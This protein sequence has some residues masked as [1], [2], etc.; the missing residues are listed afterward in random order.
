MKILINTP[1]LNLEGGVA[2][3]YKGLFHHWNEEVSYNIIGGRKGIPGILILPFDLIKFW[4]QCLIIK[5][6]LV[7]LNPS[8]GNTALLRDSFFLKLSKLLGLATL[9]FF[10]GW[11]KNEEQ[12]IN[13]NPIRFFRKFHKANGFVVLAKEF[14][15]KLLEWGVKQPI[16]LTT[17]KVDDKLIE[18]FSILKKTYQP[19]I[20]F[21]A[22][23]E[24]YK[25]IFIALEAFEKIKRVM[26]NA[27]LIIAGNG[28]SL[29]NAKDFV[30]QKNMQDV[31]FK[32]NVSGDELVDCFEQAGLYLLPTYGEGMPT[33]VLEAMAFGLP[34]VTRPVGGIPDF[35]EN[36]TMGLLIESFDSEIY[37]Q[38]SLKLLQDSEEMEQMGKY[39]Y[40]YAKENFLAS[41]VAVQMEQIFQF[42]LSPKNHERK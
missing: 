9:V 19:T 20:L 26:P 41:K 37:F 11:K 34:I 18:N 22:R 40:S 38:E 30:Q 1:A 39:N 5:P 13:A 17:T 24:I 27:K 42:Y 6:D 16:Y 14:K 35:F 10:H 32:G 8:L 31:V 23:V 12:K 7:V 2:N 4:V 33:S 3:H 28:S 25:G 21:L 15:Y 29:A 36:K